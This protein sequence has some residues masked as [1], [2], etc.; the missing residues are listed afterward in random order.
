MSDT[1]TL[2][3]LKAKID[4]KVIDLAKAIK[5]E[6][7]YK[8]GVITP[9]EGL[10]FKTLPAN[11]TQEDVEK[12][13]AHNSVF[14]PA[15]HLAASEMALPAFKKDPKLNSVEGE[16][17][18]AGKDSFNVTV[19]RTSE[20]RNPTNGETTTKYG[21]ISSTLATYGAKSSRGE[22]AN[23]KAFA[24]AAAMKALKED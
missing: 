17:K 24:Q 19:H 7:T 22:M 13:N 4:E 15:V 11:V 23:V 12:V 21:S 3:D 10:Y 1:V 20:A 16:F 18:M 2:K 9:A 8:E 5:D 6:L 14:F